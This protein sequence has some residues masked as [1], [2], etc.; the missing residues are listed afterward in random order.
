MRLCIL[1][2]SNML[3][4][5]NVLKWCPDDYRTHIKKLPRAYSPFLKR[6]KNPVQAWDWKSGKIVFVMQKIDIFKAIWEKMWPEWSI[7][8]CFYAPT[9]KYSLEERILSYFIIIYPKNQG[10]FAKFRTE[11]VKNS[12]KSRVFWDVVSKIWQKMI[13]FE[14]KWP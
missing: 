11:F 6:K 7:K 14:A 3:N 1:K 12:S 4:Q 10:K 9:I 13:S 8:S 5:W 2:C